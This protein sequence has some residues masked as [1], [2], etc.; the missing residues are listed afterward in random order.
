MQCMDHQIVLVGVCRVLPLYVCDTQRG[1]MLASPQ[2]QQQQA[3]LQACLALNG[4]SCTP[5]T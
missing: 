1:V 2:Q 4:L 3:R 5:C